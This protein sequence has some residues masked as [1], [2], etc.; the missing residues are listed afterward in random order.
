MTSTGACVRACGCS[1]VPC[2]SPASLVASFNACSKRPYLLPFTKLRMK[3]HD[4]SA[5]LETISELSSNL[6]LDRLVYGVRCLLLAWVLQPCL[7]SDSGGCFALA[8]QQH[9]F[10][11]LDKKPFERSLGTTNYIGQ[12]FPPVIPGRAPGW[13]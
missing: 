1:C 5:A 8:A 13:R 11:A 12:L 6:V 4:S 7:T 3:L 2:R 9:G 10:A